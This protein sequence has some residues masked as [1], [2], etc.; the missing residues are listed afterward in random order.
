MIATVT[1]NPSLDYIVNIN[2]FEYGGLNRTNKELILPGG[3]GINVSIVLNNLE[4]ETKAF[5]FCA[6]FTGVEFERLLSEMN[7]SSSFI[8][9]REGMTRINVKIQ[10]EKETEVNGLGPVI[11]NNE[12]DLLFEKLDSLSSSDILVLAGSIPSTLSKHI[13]KDIIKRLSEKNIKIVVDTTNELL[14]NILKYKPFLVKPNRVELGELFDITIT[15]NDEAIKYARELRNMGAQ[16]VLVSLGKDGAIL[17][18]EYNKIHISK[19]IGGKVVNSVGAGDS[20]VA[21]FLA[22]YLENKDY[23]NAFKLGL[24]AGGASATSQYLAT[25]VDIK[26]LMKV[27]EN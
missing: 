7:V 11:S 17:V 21:G 19:A 22:G 9:V 3:K 10:E 12:I 16:N 8:K 15:S 5:G 14:L 27:C 20:M 2:K 6:G 23:E 24:C 13:Y 25:A 26:K 18:D 1:L 4:I